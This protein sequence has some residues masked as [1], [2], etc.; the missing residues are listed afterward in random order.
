[1]P[2]S[3]VARMDNTITAMD[4]PNDIIDNMYVGILCLNLQQDNV[5]NIIT[6]KNKITQEKIN[7]ITPTSP[8]ELY[9]QLGS[10]A[11]TKDSMPQITNIVIDKILIILRFLIV[12]GLL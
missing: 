1:M 9:L 8:T 7:A 12:C 2:Q 11:N 3:S 5:I 6:S 4:N 10:S